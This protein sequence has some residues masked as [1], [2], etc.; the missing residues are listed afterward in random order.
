M[1]RHLCDTIIV[2]LQHSCYTV[3]G[4]ILQGIAVRK[5]LETVASLLTFR[6]FPI[7]VR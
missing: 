2:A 6:V 4:F 1:I 7:L 3:V 5:V